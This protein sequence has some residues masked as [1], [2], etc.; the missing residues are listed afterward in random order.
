MVRKFIFVFITAFLLNWLWE[1]LHSVFYASYREGSITSF[2]LFRAAIFDALVVLVIIFIS[3][4]F[5]AA[6]NS[7]TIVGGLVAAVIMEIWALGTG[8]WQYSNLMPIIPFLNI[9]LTPAIQLAFT[10]W[11]TQK[12]VF[13]N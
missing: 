4:K 5:F 12:I 7:A 6:N 13:K 10:G 1:N 2:I 3:Q 8:R 11:L 9:G